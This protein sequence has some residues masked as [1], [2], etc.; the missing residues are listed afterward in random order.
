MVGIRDEF[1]IP[2][3]VNC[4]ETPL[5][6][7]LSTSFEVEWPI[8]EQLRATICIYFVPQHEWKGIEPPIYHVIQAGR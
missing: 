4:G 3:S 8:N 5:V 2:C 1:L 7:A 6:F